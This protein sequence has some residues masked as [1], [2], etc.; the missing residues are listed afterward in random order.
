[1]HLFCAKP[2]FLYSTS[3]FSSPICCNGFL[4]VQLQNIIIHLITCIEGHIILQFLFISTSSA[5]SSVIKCLKYKIQSWG[6]AQYNNTFAWMNF[7]FTDKE[8]DWQGLLM[9]RTCGL[10]DLLKLQ[11]KKKISAR[12]SQILSKPN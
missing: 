5:H 9:K 3:V 8:S 1:M 6:P 7:S 4:I 10:S 11:E 2:R 12:L